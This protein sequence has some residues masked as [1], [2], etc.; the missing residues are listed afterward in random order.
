MRERVTPLYLNSFRKVTT[1]VSLPISKEP[2]LQAHTA[3]HTLGIRSQSGVGGGCICLFMGEL[4][5]FS[6]ST[7]ISRCH[8]FIHSGHRRLLQ[9]HR[10]QDAADPAPPLVEHPIPAQPDFSSP[11]RAVLL[12]CLRC[13]QAVAQPAPGSGSRGLGPEGRGQPSGLRRGPRAH[14]GRAVFPSAAPTPGNQPRAG[15]PGRARESA[16]WGGRARR[17]RPAPAG[18][19]ASVLSAGGSALAH[20]FQI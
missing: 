16:A 8:A 3:G 13:P 10:G 2:R 5:I 9:A 6:C 17:P 1:A 4:L 14:P 20:L 18:R 19:A 15:R 7:R 11:G 12:W